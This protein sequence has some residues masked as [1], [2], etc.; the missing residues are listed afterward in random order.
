MVVKDKPI[1]RTRTSSFGEAARD[2]REF[3]WRFLDIFHLE[4]RLNLSA[5]AADA[6]SWPRQ[7][8]A[9]Q[10]AHARVLV[11][12]VWMHHFGE[13]FVRTPDDLCVRE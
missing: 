4:A 1:R 10:P 13:G 3:R 7:S 6:S 8:R 5:R 2:G 11:N 9:G 12:R